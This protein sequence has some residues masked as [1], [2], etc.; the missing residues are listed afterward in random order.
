MRAHYPDCSMPEI[1][2]KLPGKDEKHIYVRA[3]ALGLK[4]SQAFLDSPAACR[5]RRGD[6]VGAQYRFKKGQQ[7]WNKGTHYVAGGRSAETRFKPGQKPHT[8][9]PVGSYR[10]D[11]QGLLQQKISDAKGNNSKRWR[12]VHE[13]VWVAA[14]GPVPPGHFCVFKPGMRTNKLEEITLDRVEC[15]SR[16]EHMRRNTLHNYGPE[17]AKTMQL[18][19]AITRQINK[20]IKEQRP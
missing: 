15:I 13:L 3:K 5:L 12:G 11:K 16:E 2:A 14:N 9:K 6:G 17:I 20:R 4:K 19:G 7:P 1:L 8:T 18:K 10:F